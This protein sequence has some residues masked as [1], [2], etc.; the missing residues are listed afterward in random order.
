M[1]DIQLPINK[2]QV[3]PVTPKK[4]FQ[5][6]YPRKKKSFLSFMLNNLIV[7]NLIIKQQINPEPSGLF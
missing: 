6:P 4:I 7:A 5:L 1:K 2:Q 3:T